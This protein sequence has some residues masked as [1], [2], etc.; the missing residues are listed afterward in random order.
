MPAGSG[1]R[2]Q[3]LPGSCR[4]PGRTTPV[5]A[6]TEC[7]VRRR[8]TNAVRDES[9]HPMACPRPRGTRRTT[10]AV[11]SPCRQARALYSPKRAP[12]SGVE[13]RRP[14][15]RS[16]GFAPLTA[17]RAQRIRP[18]RGRPP[19]APVSTWSGEALRALPSAARALVL[20]TYALPRPTTGGLSPATGTQLWKRHGSIRRKQTAAKLGA[21]STNPLHA[22][23][24]GDRR[25]QTEAACSLMA[26]KRS[27]VRARL[28]PLHERPARSPPGAGPFFDP[29]APARS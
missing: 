11:L 22:G 4:P 14:S 8:R 18:P 24:I 3:E 10:K 25:K 1:P 21:G 17:R 2:L 5:A 6:T 12:C 29:H 16:A 23:R 7:V 27:S 13:H 9:D 19:V 20:A 15:D 28:A 26:C